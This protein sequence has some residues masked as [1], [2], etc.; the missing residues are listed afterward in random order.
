MQEERR[1]GDIGTITPSISS[2]GWTNFR[3]SSISS[4]YAKRNGN[5][6]RINYRTNFISFL[7][8]SEGITHSK[9]VA[10]SYTYMRKRNFP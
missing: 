9:Y 1:E 2:L 5:F 8:T 7:L 3:N 4:V 10:L 6:R